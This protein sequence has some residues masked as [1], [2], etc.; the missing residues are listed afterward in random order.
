MELIMTSYKTCHGCGITMQSEH[1]DQIGYVKNLEQNYCYRCFR[2]TNYNELIDYDVAEIDF[3]KQITTTYDKK[4]TYC[5]LLDIYDLYGSRNLELEKLIANN[6]VIIIINKIDLVIKL[7]NPKKVIN[8]VKSIFVDSPLYHKITKILLVSAIKNYQLDELYHLI[9]NQQGPVYF[10]GTSNTGKSTLLNSLIKLTNQQQKITV[11]NSFATTLA[12]IEVNL[13]TKNKIY[14]T[15]GVKNEHNIIHYLAK[16]NQ[17]E[18]IVNQLI[19]PVTF[20]LNSEQ[21]IFYQGLA[22]FTYLTGPKSNFHF[23]KNNKIELHRT[24]LNNKNNYF[25]EHA[26]QANLNLA[27][28]QNWKATRFKIKSSNLYSLFISGLGWITFDGFAGQEIMIETN[29]NVA[30]WLSNDFI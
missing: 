21:T 20:Q 26:Q 19:R 14:D 8:Y 2:L 1:S 5:Y 13:G 17:K 11:A 24:K 28:Y 16:K 3:L 22:S 7:T 23:Y 30:V 15:P 4:N 10:V 27:D 9:S 18:L 29:E 12:T 25:F 6:N